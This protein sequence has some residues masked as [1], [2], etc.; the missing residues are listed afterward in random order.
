M[1]PSEAAAPGGPGD[2]GPSDPEAARAGAILTIDLDALANNYRRLCAEL[3]GGETNGLPKAATAEQLQYFETHIRPLFAEHCY[4][5]HSSK[6]VASGGLALDTKRGLRKGGSR[7]PAV[8]P[9]TPDTSLLLRVVRH[10]DVSLRMPPTGKLSDSQIEAEV[11]ELLDAQPDIS[12]EQVDATLSADPDP[13]IVE[14]LEAGLRGQSV[15]DKH[16]RLWTVGSAAM[17][18]ALLF[19][20]IHHFRGPLAG[21]NLI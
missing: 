2:P 8:M 3:N 5:C 17:A 14:A 7:G 15:G 19:Q 1:C 9:G 10:E 6:T 12:P 16:A 21:Q 20:F 13:G 4:A 18:C 11:S